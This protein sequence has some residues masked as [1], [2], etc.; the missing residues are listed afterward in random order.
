MIYLHHIITDLE[1]AGAQMMLYKLLF[2]TDRKTFKIKVTSLTNVGP[3][4]DRIKDLGIETDSLGMKRGVPN[5]TG[6]IKLRNMLK[7]SPPDILQTWMYHGDLLGGVSA[8]LADNIPVIWGIHNTTLEPGKSKRTTIWTAKACAFLSN[9]IPAKIV[10]CSEA[11]K[12]IHV[13]KGYDK[14]KMIVIQNGFD[15]NENKPDPVLRQK[16]RNE[17]NIDNKTIVIG[18]IA[19]FD[20]QKDHYNFLKAASIVHSNFKNLIFL[21]AGDSLI[22]ENNTLVKWI[23]EL[24]IR[25]KCCLLGRRDDVPDLMKALDIGVLSSHYGE[26]FP[27]VIGESM[28]SGVPCVVTDVGDSSIIV[29]D[30]GVVVPPKN[31]EKLAEGILK[32]INLEKDER[33]NLGNAAR[34]RIVENFSLEKSVKQYEDIYKQIVKNK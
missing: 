17:L 27:M 18:L 29:G 5:P 25:D 34:Q 8:K 28:A 12:E 1:A 24:G 9:T 15:L 14:N 30:T 2:A 32:I 33:L 21:M 7:K 10:C 6:I 19:R 20:P 13:K 11:S 23:D 31:P 4:G 26:A 22:W 16:V 3:V